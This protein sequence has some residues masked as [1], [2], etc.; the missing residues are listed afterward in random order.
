MG[1]KRKIKNRQPNGTSIDVSANRQLAM[2]PVAREVLG[3]MSGDRDYT[4]LEMLGL[5]NGRYASGSPSRYLQKFGQEVVGPLKSAGH[6]VRVARQ[7][8]RYGLA[9]QGN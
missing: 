7:P 3:A 2:S 8:T 4:A 6:I 1:R 5:A 9:P